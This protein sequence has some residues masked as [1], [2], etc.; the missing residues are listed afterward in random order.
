MNL[1]KGEKVEKVIIASKAF[2][3]INPGFT[4]LQ[5]LELVVKRN[6]Y[7]ALDAEMKFGFDKGASVYKFPNVNEKGLEQIR[8]TLDLF[9]KTTNQPG[10]FREYDFS[11]CRN[12]EEMRFRYLLIPEYRAVTEMPRQK[13]V[14]LEDIKQLLHCPV[15]S[16]KIISSSPRCPS[17]GAFSYKDKGRRYF[18]SDRASFFPLLRHGGTEATIHLCRIDYINIASRYLHTHITYVEELPIYLGAVYTFTPPEKPVEFNL[19]LNKPRELHVTDELFCEPYRCRPIWPKDMEV[20]KQNG[21]RVF[22][23]TGTE[24]YLIVSFDVWDYTCLEEIGN[25]VNYILY[26]YNSCIKELESTM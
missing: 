13:V 21:A 4:G 6:Q 8:L 10:V 20:L 19:I 5:Q 24:P 15:C 2:G 17:C 12:E 23:G 9:A 11:D 22:C 26:K 7:G 18:E 1:A 3:E 16:S 14:S 25:H